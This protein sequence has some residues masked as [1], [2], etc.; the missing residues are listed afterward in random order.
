M[1]KSQVSRVRQVAELKFAAEFAPAIYGG[2]LKKDNSANHKKRNDVLANLFSAITPPG[3]GKDKEIYQVI[4]LPA[5]NDPSFQRIQRIRARENLLIETLDQ[6][7]DGLAQ[8]I[9]SAYTQWRNA[10]LTEMNAIR[11]AGSRNRA[12]KAT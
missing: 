2:Y 1:A 3:G 10:R 12:G 5:E 7:Y 6:Q 8:S 11:H 9:Q 4:R